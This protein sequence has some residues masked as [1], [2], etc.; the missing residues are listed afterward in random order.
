MESKASKSRRLPAWGEQ[1]LPPCRSIEAR[2]LNERKGEI[3]SEPQH[4][5]GWPGVRQ[6]CRRVLRGGQSGPA[7]SG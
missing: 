5:A 1:Q 4:Q 7:G 2:E 3:R 6:A